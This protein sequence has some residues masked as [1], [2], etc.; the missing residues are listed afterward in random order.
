MRKPNDF[1]PTET[2]VTKLLLKRVPAIAGMILEPCAG[3]GAIANVIDKHKGVT[4]VYTN[5]INQA[6][7]CNCH[8]DASKA[9]TWKEWKKTANFEW[10]ITNPPFNQAHLILPLTY[11][12]SLVG[13]A[14]LLRLSYLEPAGNRGEWLQL[15]SQNLSNLIILGQPRPSFTGD[16]KTDSCT[17]AWMV[18]LKHY[19]GNTKVDFVSDWKN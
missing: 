15:H 18:W 5:D 19:S 2:A 1:Y 16:G 13:V 17:V 12:A 4:S 3:D 11:E 6:W 8:E 10:I 9:E 7:S 14:F